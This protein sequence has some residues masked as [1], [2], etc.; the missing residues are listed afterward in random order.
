MKNIL[1]VAESLNLTTLSKKTHK[2]SKIIAKVKIRFL[3]LHPRDTLGNYYLKRK[4]VEIKSYK[5]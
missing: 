1:N 2:K 5:N 4:T 3:M